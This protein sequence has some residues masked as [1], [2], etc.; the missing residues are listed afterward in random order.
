MTT[1]SLRTAS[2]RTRLDSWSLSRRVP[3]GCR[4]REQS[5]LSKHTISLVASDHPCGTH[6]TRTRAPRGAS[7]CPRP[8]SLKE[9]VGEEKLKKFINFVLHY[10]ADLVRS[11]QT[12]SVRPIAP[13]LRASFPNVCLCPHRCTSSHT[14][15][16]P[17]R[18]PPPPPP[19]RRHPLPAG[20]PD[21]ARH[22]HRVPQGHDERFPHR[23]QLLAGGARRVRT[24]RQGAVP[25]QR[26]DHPST[27]HW[28][29]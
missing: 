1:S 22:L 24:V 18:T 17:S 27:R 9:F 12:A 10:I 29:Y 14:D 3:A 26:R 15:R 21:Q 7:L 5:C 25:P 2:W 8:Q 13:L 23:A 28:E 20:H 19:L 16:T 6:C 4:Q 11:P